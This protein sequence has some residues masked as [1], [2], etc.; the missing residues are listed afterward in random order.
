MVGWVTLTR[1][2]GR[3]VAGEAD[4][5]FGVDFGEVRQFFVGPFARF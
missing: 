1:E 3:A 5:R 4:G 2:A